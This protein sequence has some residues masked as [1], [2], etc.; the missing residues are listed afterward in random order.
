M[1][2]RVNF[3]THFSSALPHML[4]SDSNLIEHVLI[5]LLSNSFRFT[6]KGGV[7]VHMKLC[8]SQGCLDLSPGIILPVFL[9]II[10]IL[11]YFLS[12][13]QEALEIKITDTGIGI[14][15]EFYPQIFQPF[16][17]A[18]NSDKREYNGAGLGLAMVKSIVILLGGV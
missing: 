1:N 2:T 9:K 8:A 16:S 5:N 3:V 6:H 14:P 10:F 11:I 7:E 12:S 17:Q 15:L 13:G 18:D 4:V